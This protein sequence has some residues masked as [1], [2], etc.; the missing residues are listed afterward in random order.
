[1][2]K[3]IDLRG[4]KFGRLS[5]VELLEEKY[6]GKPLW[7][8]LCDCGGTT[9][10]TQNAL[11]KGNTSSCGCLFL[12][13][14]AEKGR[15][16]IT[17]DAGAGYLYERYRRNAAGKGKI[18]TITFDEFKH[19]TSQNCHYCGAEPSQIIYSR[20]AKTPY[21]YN[22]VDRKDNSLGYEVDNCLPCCSICNY[23]KRDW[24]YEEYIAWLRKLAKRYSSV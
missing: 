5:P 23:A 6:H 14:T 21:T 3:A 12:E 16:N 17:P 18:F 7:L 9:K 13:I 10:V 15:K 19:I 1:M 20:V 24:S 22:G 8:C 2:K 4:K 11:S